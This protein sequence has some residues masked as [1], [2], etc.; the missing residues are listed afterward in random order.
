MEDGP[1]NANES[2]DCRGLRCPRPIV[3]MAKCM[4]KMESGQVLELLA[5]DP[6]ARKDVPNWCSST[7]NEFLER[8]DEDS[9]F[10]F[11]VKKTA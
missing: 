5:D 6:V 3:E 11:Y 8:R 10:R 1:V 4:R 9:F 7:G 2:V